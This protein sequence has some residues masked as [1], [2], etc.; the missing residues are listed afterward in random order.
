[1]NKKNL[2]HQN[3]LLAK[4]GFGTRSLLNQH[5]EM[6]MEQERPDFELFTE[7]FFDA[8]TKLEAKLYFVREAASGDY[9]FIKYDTLLR[10]SGE[11]D[12]DKRQTFYLHDGD[13]I[14][15]PE[16][17]NLLQGRSVYKQLI[18]PNGNPYHAWVTIDFS[19]DKDEQGNYVYGYVQDREYNL[20]IELA[21]YPI[22]EMDYDNLGD[23]LVRSLQR[24]DVR[25]VT[26]Y[27]GDLHEKK[28]ISANPPS[29]TIN[30]AHIRRIDS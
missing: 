16:A 23:N 29:K 7:A 11:H 4:L 19:R 6:L 15:F 13:G 18:G 27:H 25:S 2:E 20:R 5:L 21:K 26:F 17:F 22:L 28:A 24:G 12:K 1:M 30:V 8:E 9:Q 14:S 3:Q 10:Y